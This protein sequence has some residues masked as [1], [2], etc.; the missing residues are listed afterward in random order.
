MEEPMTN[1]MRELV[2]SIPA[3]TAVLL[4]AWMFLR[5]MRDSQKL[6]HEVAQSFKDELRHLAEQHANAVRQLAERHERALEVVVS[7]HAQAMSDLAAR[8]EK[9]ASAA[10]ALVT[11]VTR[12]CVLIEKDMR[13]RE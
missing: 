9:T 4:M 6:G 5:R 2:V 12:L 11:E 3:A 8:N 7:S 13:T 10:D 1:F